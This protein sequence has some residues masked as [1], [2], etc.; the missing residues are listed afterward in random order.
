MCGY[1]YLNDVHNV[2][3]KVLHGECIALGY[4]QE[5]IISI[6]HHQMPLCLVLPLPLW[7]GPVG[8]VVKGVVTGE[9]MLVNEY[10]SNSF[11]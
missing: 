2:H 6:L 3:V 4:V 9:R 5:K 8:G 11:S 7:V 1:L 10:T